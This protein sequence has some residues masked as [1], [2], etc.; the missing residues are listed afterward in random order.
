MKQKYLRP[1]LS[2]KMQQQLMRIAGYCSVATALILIVVKIISFFMTNSLSL[3]S[4][5]MDS[6]LDLGASI[7]SL[8]AI[9]Q[10]LVPPDKDHRFGHGKAEALGGLAQGIIIS[11]SGLFLLFETGARFLNPAPLKRFDI[12]LGVMILSILLTFIL[13]CF[14]R[15]VIKKTNSLAVDAD[16][17]HYTSDIMMNSGIIVS[18]V[19]SYQLGW[20]WMDSLFALLVAFYLFYTAYRIIS[21]V[22]SILM[23]KELPPQMRSKIKKIVLRHK[24]IRRVCDLRTRNAGMRSFVQFSIVLSGEHTLRKAHSL[25]DHLEN[26]L[27]QNLPNC[28][29]FIH[30]EPIDD[31]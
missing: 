18:M 22:Q 12:G 31:K 21:K 29:F 9:R 28:E 27:K 11:L 17:S 26:E 6:G 20:Q 25:C 1:Q 19:F 2:E 23:D 4:S 5:L 13:I 30:P 24:E 7:V 15:Y 14:Q 8:I 16:S 3:L 10:A